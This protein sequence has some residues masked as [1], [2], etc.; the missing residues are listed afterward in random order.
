MAY[1]RSLTT[2]FDEQ[3]YISI[4]IVKSFI[5]RLWLAQSYTRHQAWTDYFLTQ[6]RG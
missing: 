3:S 1:P 5:E 4:L 6:S 2:K